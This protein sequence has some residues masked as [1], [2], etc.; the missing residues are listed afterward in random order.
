MAKDFDAL[1]R[2]EEVAFPNVTFNQKV[3]IRLRVAGCPPYSYQASL[4][5]TGR[6]R[7]SPTRAT[8]AA[9]VAREIK[10]FIDH[11]RD[12]RRT[13]MHP[14]GRLLTLDDL[15]L[16]VIKHVSCASIQPVIGLLGSF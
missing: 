2:P 6:I 1:F 12:N 15:C 9:L 3:S 16:L 5:R 4:P 7:S 14:A 8:L 10:R 13:L 11:E